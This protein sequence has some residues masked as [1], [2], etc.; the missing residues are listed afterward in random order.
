MLLLAVSLKSEKYNVVT[1]C[2][3]RF[4]Y[5]SHVQDSRTR[6]S[7]KSHEQTIN[8]TNANKTGHTTN[9]MQQTHTHTHNRNIYI[10]KRSKGGK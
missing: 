7:L 3:V 9:K 4:G 6:K 5:T 10:G 8:K 1:N 2:I